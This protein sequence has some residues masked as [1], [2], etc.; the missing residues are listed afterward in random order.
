MMG[1][2]VG[3]Q[4]MTAASDQPLGFAAD[5]D[6]P[7][8]Y[9]A[10]TR[11]YYQAIGYKTPYRWAHHVDAPFKPLRMALARS[12]VA[13]VTTAAPFDP[14]KGDQ[15]PGAK[16]NG[17][18]KFY[19]VYDGDTSKPHDLRISHIAYDRVHTS[20]DDSGTWFPLPQ[21]QRLAA[22]G[23]IG[24]VAPRFFGAPTNRSH[25]VTIETDAPEILARCRADGVDAAVL[26][27]NCPVCHQ[28]IALVARHLEANGIST[29]VMGCA[30]DIVE[31][32]AV[33]RFLFSDFPLGNSAG[34]PHDPDLQA[35]TL[36]LALRVLEA[37]PGPQTTVQS[38]IRWSAD[39]SWKRDY[40]NVAQMSPEE[41][42]RRRREF[43]AQKEIARG[44]RESA[45]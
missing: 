45:A 16:Y 10:R 15:G 7:I 26:V 39:A 35:F 34:K 41:L 27:P 5:D 8:P 4:G 20:A 44:V 13:I 1:A 25:R 12:R 30:K 42:A 23:R 28:T 14:A 11:D 24:H 2:H 33:P 19:S 3:A 22:S 17:G 40:N 31:H 18:A 43:D 29:V 36:D 21:L 38:P 37:A 32:A 9:M 6:V